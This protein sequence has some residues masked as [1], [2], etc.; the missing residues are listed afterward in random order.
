MATF[1]EVSALQQIRN[2]LLGEFSPK[3]FNFANQ[4][5][6]NPAVGVFSSSQSGSNPSQNASYELPLTISDCSQDSIDFDY[7]SLNF[8]ENLLDLESNSPMNFEQNDN[9]F[10][11]FE[12]YSQIIDLTSPKIQQNSTAPSRKPPLKIDLSRVEQAERTTVQIQLPAEENKRYRGV[13]RRPWG[14]YAAEI[15]DPKRRGS[16]AWLGTFDTAVE[17]AKA[18]DRAAFRI[19]GSKAIL[20]FPLEA[21]RLRTE[22]SQAAGQ[23]CGKPERDAEETVVVRNGAAEEW[24]PTPSNWNATWDQ[25]FNGMYDL[26]PLSPHSAFGYPQMVVM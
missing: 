5:S 17:A 6:N 7:N 16:R 15:R 26:P 19:R 11:N 24:P 2:Y 21:S 23:G 4:L 9:T 8:Q 1:D 12:S 18:Y 25:N 22:E 10:T 20:N 3:A 14:K 13:R